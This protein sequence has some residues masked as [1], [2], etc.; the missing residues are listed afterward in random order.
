VFVGWNQRNQAHHED[1]PSTR[2]NSNPKPPEHELASQNF[3]SSQ[4]IK[5]FVLCTELQINLLY[6]LLLANY[7]ILTRIHAGQWCC[8]EDRL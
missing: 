8:N 5:F 1:D 2:G 3:C 7:C 6:P 4:K